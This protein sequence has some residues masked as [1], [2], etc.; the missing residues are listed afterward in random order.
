[1][2][3]FNG[4]A[5]F[6]YPKALEALGETIKPYLQAGQG[7]AHLLCRSIDAGGNLIELTLEGRTPT[8]QVVDLELMLP[9]SMVQMI[10]SAH[11]DSEFGFGPR[12]AVAPV[13]ADKA[14]PD[15]IAP[16]KTKNPKK[17]AKKPA[18]KPIKKKT[19]KKKPKA[20]PKSKQ[21]GR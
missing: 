2:T 7:G 14:V 6:L 21:S 16:S 4:Y 11:S 19:E 3:D 8:G 12:V 13:V 1:M 18:K 9:T 20:K 17:P 5:V 15:A 10:V